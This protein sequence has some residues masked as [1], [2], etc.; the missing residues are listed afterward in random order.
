MGC[1]KGDTSLALQRALAGSGKRLYLYDSFA[2]LPAKG[3]ADASPA[4]EQ[5]RAGE[6]AASKAELLVRLKKAGLPMP[7]VIKGWFEELTPE[8]LPERICFGLLDGDFYG[9][10]A[11]S[12]RLVGPRMSSGSSLVIDDY[13]NEAL[14]GVARAVNRWLTARRAKLSVV[15][16]MAV[17][18]F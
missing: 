1:Y 12:L 8:Q 2:G 11:A 7:T 4:G 17:V 9:S 3:P 10:I 6:L 13:Q 16:G 18:E 14:P 5:F 15:Q